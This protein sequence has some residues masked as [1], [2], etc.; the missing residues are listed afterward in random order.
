MICVNRT[1][2]E[3]IHHFGDAFFSLV[4]QVRRTSERIVILGDR[5]EPRNLLFKVRVPIP[6]CVRNDTCGVLEASCYR[7]K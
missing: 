1:K 4:V 5:R 3:G 7:D 6:H 2:K